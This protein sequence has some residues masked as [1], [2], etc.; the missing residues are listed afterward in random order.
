MLVITKGDE[1]TTAVH[2]YERVAEQLAREIDDGTWPPGTALPTIPDLEKRFGVSRITVRGGLEELA[3]RGLVYTGYVQ[4]RRGTIVRAQD[5]IDHYVTDSL[6]SDRLNDGSC[7]D[8][9]TEN[10]KKIGK[11]AAKRFVMHLAP[12]PENIARRLGVAPD[13][14]VVTRTVYQLL[15]DEPFSR[16][17]G[18]YPR[19]IAATAGID[20]PHDLPRGTIR[21]LIEAGFHETAHEDEVTY[22][23]ADHAIARDLSI[24]IG[25]PLVVQI[26]TAATDERVTRVMHYA[27]LA[28]RSR[29]IWELGDRTGLDVI[30]STRTPR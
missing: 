7:T 12:P 13:E 25:A 5:R 8:A 22:E 17:V 26:R 10:A 11:R 30:R 15:D 1:G 18:Y 3:R 20:T 14:L 9:F 29:L 23:T 28:E 27:R 16:E 24:A 19:D 2:A 21:A 4:G 6:R